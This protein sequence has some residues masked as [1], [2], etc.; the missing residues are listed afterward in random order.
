M[1]FIRYG[2][3]GL[4]A[5]VVVA[6]AG[7]AGQE[8]TASKATVTV[9]LKQQEVT[10]PKDPKRVVVLDYGALDSL[11]ALGLSDRVVGV[12]KDVLPTYLSAF[13][14][15]AYTNIGNLMEY[16]LETI[17]QLK[18]DL[19]IISGRQAEKAK[20]LAK[21][22]P[23]L[24]LSIDSDHY[25]DSFHENMTALGTIFGVSDAVKTK[26]AAIDTRINDLK[27]TIANSP[28]K[29][30]FLMTSGGKVRA[31]GPESRYTLLY[32][33]LKLKTV[34]PDAKVDQNQEMHGQTV[35]FEYIGE[36]KPD[37]ILYIDRDSAIGKGDGTNGLATNPFVM[38]TPAGQTG[39]IIRLDSG[40]WYL[41]GGGLTSLGLMLDDI[42]R[43]YTK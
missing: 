2:L 8:S 41:S 38:E 14:G 28:A 35:S 19:I 1:K 11:A 22:A 6:L 24:N 21:I 43:I 32:D 27:N 23:V 18:P 3:L 7:C 5:I 33:V 30:L 42:A 13:S 9:Q 26:V 12:P 29:G 17:S 34:M 4:L 10:V 36:M 15:S 40:V 16:N 37:Y 25:M 31:F 39:K 20:E